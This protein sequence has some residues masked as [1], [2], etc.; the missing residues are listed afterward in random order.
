[1]Y[2]LLRPVRETFKLFNFSWTKTSLCQGK[3]CS[4][5]FL[6]QQV[7]ITTI[8]TTCCVEFLRI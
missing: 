6:R 8:P 3:H 5:Y 2:K 1:M 7:Y 4:N